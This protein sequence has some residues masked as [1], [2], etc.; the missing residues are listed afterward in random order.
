L[1]GQLIFPCKYDEE[2]AHWRHYPF[3]A[4]SNVSTTSAIT[5]GK[6]SKKAKRFANGGSIVD[7]HLLWVITSWWPL[8]HGAAVPRR[9]LPKHWSPMTS[10]SRSTWRILRADVRETKLGPGNDTYDI[11]NIPKKS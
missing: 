6:K 9:L 2:I 4:H 10:F 8:L 7:G 11:P 1:N 5:K 3:A